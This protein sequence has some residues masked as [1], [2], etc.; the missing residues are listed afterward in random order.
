MKDREATMASRWPWGM[1]FVDGNEPALPLN[2]QTC[3]WRPF[4]L[5]HAHAVGHVG[6]VAV[7]VQPGRA[8]GAE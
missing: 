2:R 7:V 5:G 4:V 8:P 6:P 1:R 3:A